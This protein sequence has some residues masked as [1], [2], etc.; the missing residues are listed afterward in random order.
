M[1]RRLSAQAFVAAATGRTAARARESSFQACAHLWRPGPF[2]PPARPA[3]SPPEGG[4][5]IRVEFGR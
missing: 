1:E 5:L 2:A 4:Q 3:P